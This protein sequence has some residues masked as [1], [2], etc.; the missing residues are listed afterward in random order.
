MVINPSDIN[1]TVREG[2]DLDI[3]T[4]NTTIST[5]VHE[6]TPRGSGTVASHSVEVMEG[7]RRRPDERKGGDTIVE[8][9]DKEEET[10]KKVSKEVGTNH[11]RRPRRIRVHFMERNLVGGVL[12]ITATRGRLGQNGPNVR[13]DMMT[14]GKV[15][16]EGL[17]S[18]RGGI[19]SWGK[20]M[21]LVLL[22]I[23]NVG[24][25]GHVGTSKQRIQG[26]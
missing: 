1:D 13:G 15:D 17:G 5:A 4:S 8:P 26:C 21:G 7:H 22:N 23:G 11:Q 9:R 24:T 18:I 16:K 19:L 3:I 20:V 10:T 14:L 25:K 6:G 12:G 2:D